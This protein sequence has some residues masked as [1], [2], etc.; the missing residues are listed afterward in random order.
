MNGF[1]C[2]PRLTNDDCDINESKFTWFRQ[3][4]PGSRKD[5]N[6]SPLAQSFIYTPTLEDVGH[7]LKLVYYP[8]T[9]RKKDRKMMIE[10][11]CAV[12]LSPNFFPFQERHKHTSKFL[13]KDRDLR[14]VSYNILADLY[15]NS[16]Y[17]REVLFNYCPTH[18]LTI[19]YRSQLMMKELI[20][21]NADIICLQE[22][23]KKIYKNVL[24]SSL[25]HFQNFSGV[26]HLKGGQVGEGLTTLF[27]EDKFEIVQSHKTL[28][29][30][31]IRHPYVNPREDPVDSEEDS[32][33][34]LAHPIL[35]DHESKLCQKLLSE[36]D[37]IRQ[38]IL[39]KPP[40]ESR[41]CD[42]TTILQTTLLRLK[43]DPSYLVLVA[44]THLYSMADAD[45][46]RLLQGSICVKYLE[47]L[48]TNLRLMIEEL[49]DESRLHLIFCG[50][51][52]S[53][54]DCGLFQLVTQGQVGQNSLDWTSNKEEAVEGLS[55]D[56]TLRLQPAYENI[57]YTNYT[58]GFHGCLDYI[59]YE[60]EQVKVLQAVPP[61]Y[62]EDVVATGGIPSDVFPSDHIALVA[63]LSL[64]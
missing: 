13:V 23:D 53:T 52:N 34:L 32:R 12:Q 16:D 48:K 15:A 31:L 17:S 39:K 50:D 5:H 2:I 11:K 59:Y 1:P 9:G 29:R 46:I 27:R 64:Q 63:D 33:S 61:P 7:N 21:Y 10:T 35:C 36:Y 60:K 22:V 18:A 6:Y 57:E 37:D 51:M 49:D 58:P 42:R 28:L 8:T 56:T 26:F 3:I 24:S 47:F 55:I 43:N 4:K 62:H 20:G 40:L 38:V 45:H 44:N 19:D 14:V 54:P 25:R 41:F 30:H